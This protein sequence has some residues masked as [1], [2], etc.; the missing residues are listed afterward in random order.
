MQELG[1]ESNAETFRALIMGTVKS[2]EGDLETAEMLEANLIQNRAEPRLLI[3]LTPPPDH[4]RGLC[5]NVWFRLML[6]QQDR[7][8][9]DVSSGPMKSMKLCQG[10]QGSSCLTRSGAGTNKRSRLASGLV[11]AGTTG[12]APAALA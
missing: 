2:A 6:I 12:A 8:G 7:L 1:I 5:F 11:Q 10:I 3:A 9:S 4:G